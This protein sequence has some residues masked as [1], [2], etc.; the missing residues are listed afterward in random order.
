MLAHQLRGG[1]SG[2]SHLHQHGVVGDAVFCGSRATVCMSGGLEMRKVSLSGGRAGRVMIF[3]ARSILARGHPGPHKTR[4]CG[5]HGD[6]C[7]RAQTTWLLESM[8]AFGRWLWGREVEEVT[9]CHRKNWQKSGGAMDGVN[10]P[11]AGMGR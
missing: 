10:R 9:G 2:N 4:H 11:D 7:R 3:L 6:R 5:D 8:R 1:S